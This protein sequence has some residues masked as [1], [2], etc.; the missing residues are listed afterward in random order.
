VRGV[1]DAVLVPEGRISKKGL[2]AVN[3]TIQQSPYDILSRCIHCGM[4]LPACP[5]YA[6]TG[7]EM[8]SPRGR[9]RLMKFVAEDKLPI[10]EYFVDEMYFCLDCQACQTVCPAGVEYGELVENARRLIAENRK[11]PL[12]V[13]L[14]KKF[15]LS[16]LLT[17]NRRLKFASRVMSFYERSGL[18]NAVEQSGLLSI[19]SE[20][21]HEKHSMLPHVADRFFDDNVPEV[22]TPETDVK[23]RVGFLTGCIM[24]VA[25]PEVHRDAVEVL[26]AHGFEVVIPRMQ[27]CCGSLHGHN[28]EI[29]LAKKLAMINLDV[30]EQYEMDSFVVDSA[31]CGAFL[32][33]YGRLLADHPV[34][35]ARASAFSAK[36]KEITE[37]LASIELQPCPSVK[38]SVTYHEACHLIHTQKI[39]AQPRKLIQSIPGVQFVE[40]PEASWCCGSA[41]I[42]NIV[43]F[44]DSKKLLERKM[45]HVASTH[46][47]IVLTANPGCHLQLQY[48]VKKYGLKMEVMHPV[49]LLQRAYGGDW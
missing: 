44:D 35:G 48:G 23:G 39:S 29:D 26:L 28:G 32:K 34:Y 16:G 33:E 14:V 10:T 40:L 3:A 1:A 6:L 17:S 20:R 49:S 2:T 21:L 24:N 45:Q 43:R 30:L 12:A 31:G 19:V 9:I 8:S 38:A 25:L 15:F 11:D 4:C 7:L 27:G 46:A 36:V 13:R 5:T 42:Y 47:D 41:G 22:I 37:F 18:R